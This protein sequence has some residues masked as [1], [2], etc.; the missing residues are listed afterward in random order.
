MFNAERERSGV[1]HYLFVVYCV[2]FGRFY[3]NIMLEAPTQYSDPCHLVG[4]ALFTMWGWSSYVRLWV[5]MIDWCTYSHV[6]SVTSSHN[7]GKFLNS[8]FLPRNER[9]F[10]VFK[11]S[12]V[13]FNDSCDGCRFW[14]YTTFER[15]KPRLEHWFKCLCHPLGN[16]DIVLL[17]SY[18]ISNITSKKMKKFQH[19]SM[20]PRKVRNGL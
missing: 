9:S 3:V 11:D 10:V 19:V 2:S 15:V 7:I 17:T 20:C 5:V 18:C 14:S 4:C 16:G 12:C 6:S 8:D 1:S 13:V